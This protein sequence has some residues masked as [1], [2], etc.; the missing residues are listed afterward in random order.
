MIDEVFFVDQFVA[1]DLK[2]IFDTGSFRYLRKGDDAY[3]GITVEGEI[4]VF[5]NVP[6][7]PRSDLRDAP[8]GFDGARILN[9]NLLIGRVIVDLGFGK[10]LLSALVQYLNQVMEAGDLGV[11]GRDL[12]F[13][14]AGQNK[15]ACLGIC[16]GLWG[17]VDDAGYPGIDLPDVLLSGLSGYGIDPFGG[18]AGERRILDLSVAFQGRVKK[19]KFFAGQ[20]LIIKVFR[21]SILE[22]VEDLQ[23]TGE[24]SQPVIGNRQEFFCLWQ[25]ALRKRFRGLAK[26]PVVK[27]ESPEVK[28]E[29]IS[30][31][32][33]CD[34]GFISL[35]CLPVIALGFF[36][37]LSR[38]GIYLTATTA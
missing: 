27:I 5:R 6:D 37:Q 25:L 29:L 30:V 31:F 11:F 4:Q 22:F 18:E 23:G 36:S 8:I 9:L 33:F 14:V 13:F 21:V 28:I 32:A 26:G 15:D 38:T 7:M 1:V 35:E 19:V 3:A 34:L 16:F 20:A 10:V 12:D 2:L 17:I 24:I